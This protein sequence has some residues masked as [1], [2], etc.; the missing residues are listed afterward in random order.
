MN[1]MHEEIKD[2]N[3]LAARKQA[4]RE[5]NKKSD[6]ALAFVRGDLVM[7]AAQDNAANILRPS[8]AMVKWQGPYEVVRRV[9]ATEYDVRLMGDPEDRV[10]PV[11]W[12]RMKRFAGADF[13]RSVE[14]VEGAQ[15]DLQ[16]FYVEEILDWRE[17]ET[18]EIELLVQWRGF[19]QTWE[20]LD[21]LFADVKERV[22]K[23][24][25]E[26]SRDNPRLKEEHQ[27]LRNEPVVKNSSGV[28]RVATGARG[29]GRGGRTSHG[30]G[31]GGRSS[32]GRGRGR[33]GRSSRGRGRGARGRGSSSR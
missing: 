25:R 32:R 18:G 12:T 10:K 13:A 14:L 8:K 24:L 6:A 31:R 1:I 5:A 29:R 22:L 16:K 2:A 3:L 17:L 27:R 20:P 26:N 7:I 15:H 11:H 28:M 30:R 9:S 33:G 21:Q 23:Y 19:E 4:A